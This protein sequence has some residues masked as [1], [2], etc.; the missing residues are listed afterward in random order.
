M[1]IVLKEIS[2]VNF[3]GI[4]EFSCD[5]NSDTTNIF[6][7]NATGKTSLFDAFT[8]LLFGKDSSD[9]KDFQIKTL[10][11]YNRE[12][13]KIEHEVRA[14]LLVDGSTVEL[15]RVFKEKWTKKRGSAEAEFT[16]NET[17]YFWNEVPL[18]QKEY[19]EKVTNILEEG[20][21]KLITNTLFFNNMKWQERR[22][23]LLQLAGDITNQEILDRLM[24]VKNKGAYADLINI[25]NAGKSLA[26]YKAELA[27]KRKKLKEAIE[28]IPARIDEA[29]RGIPESKDFEALEAERAQYQKDIEEIDAQLLDASKV[30]QA[31]NKKLSD[32]QNA[33]HNLQTQLKE[34]EFQLRNQ[35]ANA[36]LERRGVI[37]QTESEIRSLEER[38]KGINAD[39]NENTK[40]LAS[41]E[42][43]LPPL[44]A[45][46]V[47]I[48]DERLEF[49]EGQFDCPACKRELETS[50]AE[51]KKQELIENFNR[52]KAQRM[53]DT[54]A[55]ADKIKA[56]ITK[57]DEYFL[58]FKAALE[59]ANA[60]LSLKV[61]Q[62][63]DLVINNNR[64]SENEAEELKS[65]LEKD[66]ISEGLFQQIT[67][68]K[69]ASE[70]AAVSESEG[71]SPLLAKK[72]EI[73]EWLSEINTLLATKEQI[74][75]GNARVLELQDEEKSLAQQIADL[76]KT[77]FAIEEFNKAKM[78]ELES[79]INGRF[80]FVKF[81]LFTKQINGGE[82][83]TCETL[84]DGVPFSDANN[85]AR[86]NAGLDIINTL[87]QHHK[88][89]A[90]IFVDNA[91]SVVSLI[92]TRSQ[93]VR[94][95]VSE[96]HKK[97]TV[98]K[99]TS[100]LELA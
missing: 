35:F 3:K 22:G 15:R 37:Q 13:P 82:S 10:D 42:E 69:N 63:N 8:W 66:S 64:I 53:A 33:I 85:A 100:Q 18:Q 91:E 58:S 93:V 95:V 52:H 78:D 77:E 31:R 88:V 14:T 17:E 73:V 60:S 84:I 68:L 89:T 1:N 54:V 20:L 92:P 21:F 24:N 5:F 34:R 12:I 44:R 23:V 59:T 94:L 49:K 65:S 61:T 55:E 51:A 41:A 32:N 38:V 36:G 99:K 16:G 80:T 2:L 86:I 43:L 74:K 50:D 19:Q 79:R 90:P 47:S 72:R 6:G 62:L 70:P 7:D 46:W 39:L 83:E 97:L 28:H 76:E 27:S 40:T 96:A 57:L 4:K 45:K 26:E 71:N 98:G 11:K 9:R 25:L 29:H 87:C 56:R 48:N 67:D 81:K 75:K 30:N